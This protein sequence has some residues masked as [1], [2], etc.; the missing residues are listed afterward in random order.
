MSEWFQKRFSAMRSETVNRDY[1]SLLPEVMRKLF[2]DEKKRE[3][4]E[5]ILTSATFNEPERVRLGILRVSNGDL[6]QMKRLVQLAAEDWR[7]LLCVTE[8]PLSSKKYG[9]REKDPKKYD[10]LLAKEQ[11]QYDE[12]VKRVLA[13]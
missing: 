4:A 2:R 10:A 7:D 3:E 11:S 5:G 6:E 8:Y 12:W 9:L 13:L 1:A